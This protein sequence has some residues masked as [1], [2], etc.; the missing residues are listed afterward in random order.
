M[1]GAALYVLTSVTLN[2]FQGLC[3]PE[4]TFVTLNLFQDLCHPEPTCVVLNLFQDLCHPAPT[5]VT[6]NLFQ[7]LS[8]LGSNEL[9]LLKPKDLT[10]VRMTAVLDT[11][12]YLF[13]LFRI[14]TRLRNLRVVV[15]NNAYCLLYRGT[16]DVNIAAVLIFDFKYISYPIPGL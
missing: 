9:R 1:V 13:W 8:H 5:S 3:H 10:F 15:R 14:S 6:L 16:Y 7:G 2:L 12:P 11:A 4:P